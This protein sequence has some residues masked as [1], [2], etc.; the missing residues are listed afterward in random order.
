MGAN[1]SIVKNV[2]PPKLINYSVC[3]AIPKIFTKDECEK[4]IALFSNPTVS[5]LTS[6]N[7]INKEIRS[8]T[9]V[10]VNHNQEENFWLMERL[11]HF[12]FQ[13]NFRIWKFDIVGLFEQI[14]LIRYQAG[15]FVS[16]HQDIGNGA[17]SA[18]KLAVSIQLSPPE[19]YTEG[20]LEFILMKKQL[21][22]RAQ[23]TGVFFPAYQVHRITPIGS[24]ERFSLVAWLSGNSYT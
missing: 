20:N 9:H 19:S 11:F 14:E 8:S 1:R 2:F 15:D 24:G 7:K 13:A 12:A 22:Y 18:R 5:A 23:G 3:H 10:W 16:W 21:M 6:G 4:I 17:S